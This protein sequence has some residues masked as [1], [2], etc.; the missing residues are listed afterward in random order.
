MGSQ[1]DVFVP[2]DAGFVPVVRERQRVKAGLSVL[3]RRVAK[4]P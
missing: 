1:V 2:D 3:M 4:L